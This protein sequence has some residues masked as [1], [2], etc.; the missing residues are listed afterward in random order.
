MSDLAEDPIPAGEY[1]HRVEVEV[2]SDTKL[3]TVGEQH[4]EHDYAARI[5]A[6]DVL[7]RYQSG[8]TPNLLPNTG[9]MPF[10]TMLASKMIIKLLYL[11]L[12]EDAL[13]L[14]NEPRSAYQR[15]ENEAE[16]TAKSCGNLLYQLGG[17]ALLIHIIQI[18]IPA[19]DQ[20]SLCLAWREYFEQ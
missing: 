17:T 3:A 16:A 13:C 8:F 4:Y 7:Q 5:R 19:L 18:W 10:D 9:Q 6:R 12:A 14:A 11:S 20:D 2:L 15:V 1:A